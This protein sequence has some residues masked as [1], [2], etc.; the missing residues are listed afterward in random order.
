[1]KTYL[2]P[3]TRGE[4]NGVGADPGREAEGTTPWRVV[5]AERRYL[6]AIE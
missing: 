2:P 3:L 5:A 6:A 4:E 1:M